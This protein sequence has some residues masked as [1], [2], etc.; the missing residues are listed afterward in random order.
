MTRTNSSWKLFVLFFNLSDRHRKLPSIGLLTSLHS[1]YIFSWARTE[2]RSWE[3]G[4]GLPT[5]GTTQ[6]LKV[7][8]CLLGP[9][10]TGSWGQEP[11]VSIK[12]GHSN[13]GPKS[14]QLR[15][16]LPD[17]MLAPNHTFISRASKHFFPN[18]TLFCQQ[19]SAN[20]ENWHK[21]LLIRKTEDLF[22]VL[23]WIYGWLP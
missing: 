14:S 9:V 19:T 16:Q 8:W 6:L 2:A 21:F 13:T 12:P 20:F 7:S 23:I 18:M 10:L 22:S 11:E 3:H 17:Q 1:G 5:S 4:L 15:A